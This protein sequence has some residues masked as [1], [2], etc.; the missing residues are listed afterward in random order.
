MH[1]TPRVASGGS[2]RLGPI[3]VAFVPTACRVGSLVVLEGT[4]MTFFAGKQFCTN[5]VR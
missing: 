4:L 1:A 2:F 5:S 3:C